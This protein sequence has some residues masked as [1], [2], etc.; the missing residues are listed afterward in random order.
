MKKYSF[1]GKTTEEALNLG[2]EELKVTKEDVLY[3]EID[4]SK[5]GLFKAKKVEIEIVKKSDILEDIKTVLNKV[6]NKMGIIANYEIKKRPDNVMIT[7][8]TENNESNNILIG[9]KGRTINSL[10]LIM[11]Q[12]LY[13]ELGINYNFI[14]DVADYKVKNQKRLE[15]LAKRVAREVS[16]SKV[17]AK[18]DPMNSYERRI[19]HSI[20]TDNPK[21][22]TESVGEEPN[23]CVVIKAK[24]ED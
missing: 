14:L 16:R 23:R 8:I 3:K 4:S 24:E 9:K 18:L 12:Y 2:L 10:S 5:G 15:S 7:V 6:I 13:N 19:I 21:V 17:D 20:L 11:K 22:R 1:I